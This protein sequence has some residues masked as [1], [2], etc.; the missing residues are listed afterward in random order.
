MAIAKR[1]IGVF[2]IASLLASPVFAQ[3]KSEMSPADAMKALQISGKWMQ[4]WVIYAYTV[5]VLEYSEYLYSEEI[6]SGDDCARLDEAVIN[7][8]EVAQKVLPKVGD[9]TLTREGHAC[10]DA[11][12]KWANAQANYHKTGAAKYKEI[13]EEAKDEME[14]HGDN[15]DDYLDSLGK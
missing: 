14:K 9:A 5:P 7:I 11:V 8:A 12:I 10:V 13:I 1:L 2:C 4:I 15:I 3:E 6:V